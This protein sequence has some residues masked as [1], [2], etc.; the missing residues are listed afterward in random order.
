MKETWRDVP[1]LEGFYSVSS[2]GSVYSIRSGK[3]L[4]QKNSSG[5]KRVCLSVCGKRKDVLVHRLVALAFIDNPEKK[6]TVNHI[7]ENKCDNRVENLEWATHREQ[8]V[9]G[10]RLERARANTDYKARNIDYSVVA[11]KHN[12]K[13]MGEKFSRPVAKFSQDGNFIESYK[14]LREASKRTEV[15]MG[16]L[17]ECLSGKRK[18][19]GGYLWRYVL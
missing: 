1:G 11:A 6:P 17:S 10:T 8:N 7:N 13:S 4:K 14:S 16:H 18:S 2:F 12:Y 19:A 15:N 9:H 5:Y 3:T